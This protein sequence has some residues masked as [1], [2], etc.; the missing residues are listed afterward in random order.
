PLEGYAFGLF[1]KGE[2]RLDA[3]NLAAASKAATDRLRE[4]GLLK[5]DSPRFIAAEHY[6]PLRTEGGSGLLLAFVPAV[7][8]KEPVPRLFGSDGDGGTNGL[9]CGGS[10]RPPPLPTFCQLPSAR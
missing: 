6:R 8:P 9:A 5:G 1:G 10:T 2:V 4:L 7:R 3:A